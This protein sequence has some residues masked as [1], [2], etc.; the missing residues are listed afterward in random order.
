MLLLL[1]GLVPLWWSVRRASR[2]RRAVSSALGAAPRGGG[3]KRDYL[4]LIALGLMI[5]GLA[6]PGYAPVRQ[7]VST[8]GR[9]VLFVLDVSR[10][11]LAE[12][13]PPS[14]LES[15]K[16]GIRDCLNALDSER[17]GL[18]IYA[19]SSNIACP[20]TRDAKF[21][22]FMVDQ[23]QPRSVDF[24]GSFLQSAV[25]KAVDQVFTDGR[26]GFQDMVVLTDG[27]DHGPGLGKLASMLNE[28][29]VDLLVVGLGDAEV[30]A[31]IPIVDEEGRSAYLEYEGEVVRSRLESGVLRELTEQ[32]ANSRYFD[33][34]T[35]PFHL[36]DIYREFSA[37]K[38]SEGRIGDDDFVVYREGALWLMS[39]A[40]VLLLVP[41]WRGRRVLVGG[42]AALG[43][44][45]PQL[46]AE[47]DVPGLFD[48]AVGLVENGRP[49]EA[50]PLLDEVADLVA[51]RP[52]EAA[53]VAFNRG[54]ALELQLGKDA[55]LP[56]RQRLA[57]AMQV[58][59]SY[60]DAARMDPDLQRASRRLDG[61]ALLIGKLEAEVADEESREQEIQEE[62]AK[63]IERLDLLLEAQQAL[64]GTTRSDG[65]PPRKRGDTN[66]AVAPE[67]AAV[68]EANMTGK[69][70]ILREE[71]EG[72]SSELKQLE[73]KLAVPGTPGVLE[74]P[75]KLMSEAVGAQGEAEEE[76]ESW[77]R[78]PLSEP[79]QRRALE[80][81]EEVISLLS[82]SNSGESEEGEYEDEGD[83]ED[84]EEGAEG[85]GDPS[86]LPMDGDFN[87]SDSIQ[88]LPLPNLSAEEILREEMGN[89]QFRQ[90]QRA[91][92]KAGEVK[93]DW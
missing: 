1:V 89:Q 59:G 86:S 76:L 26:H 60:L 49:G 32:V 62:L 90:Q 4:R 38:P 12:D 5:I 51:D 53:V 7:S 81:I 88:P 39:I 57:M 72:I 92:S 36:G 80:R 29:G 25:E 11:M 8:A 50:L 48:E 54:L 21:V 63:L 37:N 84:W 34:G 64:L 91:K 3:K 70:A 77:R 44:T 23:A 2:E 15:A 10:S 20:L 69:Q 43:M 14:R 56:A 71:A 83:Y 46:R 16:Q 31:R 82:D 78:W 58:Q 35:S 65:P 45:V 13:V 6:R 75:L 66:P 87:S 30:G 93:K 73:V 47:G 33:A 41:E 55:A 74:E 61:T 67:D 52:R 18:V 68:R 42:L 17:S 22:R 79:M 27:G 85:E 28:K 19:G 40:L 24:G 9:D